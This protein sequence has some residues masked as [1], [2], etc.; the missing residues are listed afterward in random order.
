MT[1]AN[2]GTAHFAL[3][4]D[5]ALLYAVNKHGYGNWDTVREVIRYD[6]ALLFQHTV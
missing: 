4:Q 1:F 2:K 3:E 5:R 6:Q